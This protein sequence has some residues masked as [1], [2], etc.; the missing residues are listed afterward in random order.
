MKWNTRD[1]R[2]YNTVTCHLNYRN[3]P[4]GPRTMRFFGKY[5]IIYRSYIV[6]ISGV[7]GGQNGHRETCAVREMLYN[8][9]FFRSPE[10]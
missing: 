4:R 9:Y 5:I 3:F 10:I 1:H 6:A 8:I 7:R 2:T